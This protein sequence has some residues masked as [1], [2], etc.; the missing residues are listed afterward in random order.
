MCVKIEMRN[1]YAVKGV[2]LKHFGPTLFKFDGNSISKFYQG[3]HFAL[4]AINLEIFPSVIVF[5]KFNF[6]ANCRNVLWIVTKC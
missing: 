1:L 4:E 2:F 6:I 3:L 5:S